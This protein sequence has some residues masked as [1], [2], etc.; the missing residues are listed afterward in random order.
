MTMRTTVLTAIYCALFPALVFAQPG[1]TSK[2]LADQ[3]PPDHIHSENII[4]PV[5]GINIYE[6]LNFALEGDSTRDCKGYACQA[7]VEDFYES[8]QLLHR[9]YY[10]DGQLK[11]YKNYY[12]DGQLEREFKAIDNYR[13]LMRKYYRSGTLK[14]EVRYIEGSAIKW[15]D[16]F[17]NGKIE[18]HE[19]YHK[20]FNY[21]LKREKYNAEG[22]TEEFFEMVDRKKLIFDQKEFHTNGQTSEEGQLRYDKNIFDFYRIGKW[23]FYDESGKLIKEIIYNKGTIQKEKEY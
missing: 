4:D 1:N 22:K 5:Y 19:E 17:E 10:L 2:D 13:S 8:G 20:S 6:G 14:S 9:G 3:V 21:H 12:P 11:V 18:Y 23:L 15:T 7:W 16:Y